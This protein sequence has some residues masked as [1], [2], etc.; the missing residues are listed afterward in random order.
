MQDSLFF[1]G[2]AELSGAS[3]RTP[4]GQ[5]GPEAVGCEMLCFP[6]DFQGFSLKTWISLGFSMKNRDSVARL[7][8]GV[9]R[10]PPLLPPP[11]AGCLA[12]LLVI[13]NAAL[14]LLCFPADQGK[15]GN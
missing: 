13:R 10:G 9:L 11:P 4:A 8:L 5:L 15:R 7:H 3:W 12:A 2:G 14:Q 1:F 6:K